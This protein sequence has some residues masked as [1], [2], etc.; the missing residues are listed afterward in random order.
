MASVVD[1]GDPGGAGTAEERSV[2]LVRELIAAAAGVFV[3]AVAD[4]VLWPA[5]EIAGR[6]VT[7]AFVCGIVAGRLSDL[8]TVGG[9]IVM[10]CSAFGVAVAGYGGDHDA[11]LSYWS[12]TRLS[13]WRCCWASATA[14]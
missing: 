3:A 9:L 2:V 10:A 6:A 14:G 12:Y 5:G 1:D 4:V 11:D 7:L 8:R 13:A